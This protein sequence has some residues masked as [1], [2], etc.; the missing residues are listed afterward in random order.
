LGVRTHHTIRKRYGNPHVLDCA[1]LPSCSDFDCVHSNMNDLSPLVWPLHGLR[2]LASTATSTP[3][4]W[5]SDLPHALSSTLDRLGLLQ[6]ELLA[7]TI[8]THHR[9]HHG[10]YQHQHRLHHRHF[11]SPSL[12]TITAHHRHH[13]H[14]RH[15]HHHHHDSFCDVTLNHVRMLTYFSFFISNSKIT[16]ARRRRSTASRRR[17]CR[18]PTSTAKRGTP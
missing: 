9:R 7:T 12:P 18:G 1:S 16:R 10:Q 3:A 11:L 8:T 2:A 4:A 5:H 17:R 15:H 6:H 14:H 13:Q